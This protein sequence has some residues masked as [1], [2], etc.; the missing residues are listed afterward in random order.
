MKSFMYSKQ[1]D[2][3]WQKKWQETEIYRFDETKITNKFYLLEMF[4]YPSG[5]T[6]H[7]GHWWNY[8]LS[9]SYGRL[10]RMQGYNVFHPPGFDAF[11]L[12]AENYAIKTGVHPSDSTKT[13]IATMENQFRAMG[14]TYDWNYEVVTCYEEYYK[15]TQWL[16]LKLFEKGLAYRKEAPVNWC[17]SCM[18]VLANEQAAGGKCER[19]DSNVVHRNMTQWFFKITEYAEE[20][21]SGLDTL[22]WPEKTKAI[23]KNWIGKSFGAEINFKSGNDTITVFTTRADTL[24]GVTYIVLAPEHPLVDKLTA[25]DCMEQVT[26]YRDYTANQS[27]IERTSTAK[28]KSGV[29]TGAYAMHPISGKQIPIWVA[30]YVLQNYGTGAVMAVPAHDERDFEF[31]EK[32]NLPVIRV[33][34]GNGD[35]KSELPFCD[36]GILINSG[37][38]NGLTSEQARQKISGDL[39]VDEKGKQ[40]VKY[41]LRDWLVSRQRYWGAPIPIIHCEDCGDVP[42][43]ENELPVKLP[44]NVE[45][46]PSGKSPLSSCAEFVNTPCPICGKPAKRDTDT[47]DTFVCSS[48]Y[49]LRFYDNKNADVPFDKTRVNQIMPLDKYVGGIEHA[50]MH[51][52]YARFV[53]KAL[54]DMGYL[55]FGEPFPSL[56]HQGIITGKDGKKMSKR[57]G[58]ASPD[59]LIEQYGSDVFRMYLGFGFSYV[60]GGPWDDD[61]IKAIA[62]FVSRI[63][64][65]AENFTVLKAEKIAIE[66]AADEELEYVRNYTIKQV[67]NDL[68]VFSFNTAIARIMEFVNAVSDYQKKQN[69]NS[70]YEQ[71]LLKDLILLLAPLAPHLAEELWEYIGC[72]YSVHNQRFPSF[73][74]SKLIRDTINIAVQ[75]NGT[76]R[77]VISINNDMDEDEI[78]QKALSSTKVQISIGGK[79]IKKI[80]YIKGRIVNIVC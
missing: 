1:T 4:S 72:S 9:D 66:Y 31:A 59:V 65:L 57:N 29:F 36:D 28:E 17:P 39:D 52:L 20:L 40:T 56:F 6:L 63:G 43:P 68:E 75:V 51:L 37:I 53:T 78:K 16:F 33:V 64:R 71:T 2:Q 55:N 46:H 58:A 12:P 60:D 8:G 38:Y 34:N 41:R 14:T 45:F 42:V 49:F 74:E 30:D 47:L 7:T 11:G 32:Y 80:I 69:R 25:T 5:K 76:L 73:D 3:K 48:W 61:G 77:D 24:M 35:D 44:Y 70:I 23:Q 27:E 54:R 19:C 21:L 26:A 50:A 13:N 10:K 79:Y 18:T 22:D 67:A 62:R 15:W